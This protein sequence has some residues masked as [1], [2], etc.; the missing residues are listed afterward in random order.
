MI[1]G[2]VKSVKSILSG[3]KMP[4]SPRPGQSK[5]TVNKVKVASGKPPMKMFGSGC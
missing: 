4:N 5:E 3:A 2:P 1:T